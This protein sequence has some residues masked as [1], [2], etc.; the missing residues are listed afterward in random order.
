MTSNFDAKA[1]I[2][3]LQTLPKNIQNNVVVGGIRA[4]ANVVREEARRLV[5]VDKGDLKKS[6][7]TIR[8]KAKQG[9]ITFSVTASKG[10]HRSWHGH[11]V[12]FG[13]SKMVAKPFLRPALENKQD[14]VLEAA[15]DYI[16]NR[17]PNEVAKARRR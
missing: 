11:F 4:G 9:E 17:L 6:L 8:R 10:K 16:G 5:P 14:E 3:T 12:E 13:T 7:A 2:K 1:L 15:K